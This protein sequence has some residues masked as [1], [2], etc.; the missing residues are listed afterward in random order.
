MMECEES[1]IEFECP[2]KGRAVC[3]ARDAEKLS[4]LGCGLTEIPEQ[5]GELGKLQKLY[6]GDNEISEIEGLDA[7]KEL[8]HLWL[9]GNRIER[10]EGL[11]A[12]KEL[13]HLWLENNRIE[14]I[15]GLESLKKLKKLHLGG[16]PVA[17]TRDK[18]ELSFR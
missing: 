10:I 1:E 7:L 2:A 4:L 15:E 18:L 9:Q 5:V 3:A 12:L 13:R 16:N 17:G 8:Q 14:R 11:D 6:L